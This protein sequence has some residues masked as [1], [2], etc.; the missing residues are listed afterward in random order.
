M[1]EVVR[2]D[3]L[4]SPISFETLRSGILA[5]MLLHRPWED[6]STV[7]IG[8]TGWQIERSA[9]L[10]VRELFESVGHENSSLDCGSGPTAEILVGDSGRDLNSLSKDFA[11]IVEPLGDGL[12][13]SIS[14]FVSNGER[15][16]GFKVDDVLRRLLRALSLIVDAEKE[17]LVSD[18]PVLTPTEIENLIQLS[19]E[20]DPHAFAIE[21][22][23]AV[24]H[25][26]ISNALENENLIA[27]SCPG[28]HGK[29]ETTYLELAKM[30]LAIALDL[31]SITSAGCVVGVCGDHSLGL[32]ASEVGILLAGCAF[33]PIDTALPSQ[34]IAIMLERAAVSV[35]VA[36]CTHHLLFFTR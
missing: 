14:L 17:S 34:R 9:T 3:E 35:V 20:G 6:L 26:F 32:I 1:G 13:S 30:S 29:T 11:V 8:C 28:S 12:I 7:F 4:P 21:S 27:V 10:T 16:W 22:K 36:V 19:G 25:K 24:H 33:M 18:L 23:I 15:L 5:V 2:N 31:G